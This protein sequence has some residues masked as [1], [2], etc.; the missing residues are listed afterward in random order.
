MNY[1]LSTLSH[2]LETALV[3]WG[4]IPED[5]NIPTPLP[6]PA[7]YSKSR[8]CTCNASNVAIR[9]AIRLHDSIKK[10]KHTGHTNKS[11][12]EVFAVALALQT[13]YPVFDNFISW[14]SVVIAVKRSLRLQELN[15]HH[16]KFSLKSV[17][18]LTIS[19]L[20]ISTS[21]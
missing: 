18:R 15:Y 11:V 6:F 14:F 13:I 3:L 9:Q 19:T 5:T 1:N 8:H 7:P 20:N 4:R 17:Q 12:L 10:N 2:L 21:L 16:A